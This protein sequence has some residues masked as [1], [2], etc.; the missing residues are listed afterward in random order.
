MDIIL[1]LVIGILAGW[2]A[3]LIM[4]GGGY[5]ILGDLI[6][7]I[8]GAYLGSWILDVL[9]LSTYGIIGYLI[10]SVLGAVVLVALI[11]MIKK[12]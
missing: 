7:G 8:V 2:L 10:M 6:L 5:G 3:G 9:G 4:K 12:A 1:T 11:R